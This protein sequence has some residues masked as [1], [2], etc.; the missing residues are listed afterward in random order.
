MIHPS[1]PITDQST[2]IMPPTKPPLNQQH[3]KNGDIVD[4]YAV[5]IATNDKDHRY[6]YFTDVSE[7][8]KFNLEYKPKNE[9]I[10][11]YCNDMSYKAVYVDG[12]YFRL[13]VF[14]EIMV[15]SVEN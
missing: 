6:F 1:L 10:K 14:H 5:I 15:D 7:Q 2:T 13:S 11:V 3:Y 4:V 9:S 12:K 8:K